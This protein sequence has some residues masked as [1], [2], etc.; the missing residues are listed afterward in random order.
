MTAASFF[1]VSRLLG[2]PNEGVWPGVSKLRD[3]HEFPNW[4]PQSLARAVP[5]LVD[6]SGHAIDFLEVTTTANRIVCLYRSVSVDR[7]VTGGR[8]VRC[9]QK[10]LRFNPSDRISAK[11]ALNHPYFDDLDKSQY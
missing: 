11:D 10:M 4:Q 1:C 7:V 5:E 6:E 3:W 2:T 9:V 8:A